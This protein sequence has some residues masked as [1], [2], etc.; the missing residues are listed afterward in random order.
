MIEE[1]GMQPVFHLRRG[2]YSGHYFSMKKPKGAR[3]TGRRESACSA[4]LHVLRRR[5]IQQEA[6]VRYAGDATKRGRAESREVGLG[7][8]LGLGHTPQFPRSSAAVPAVISF[9]LRVIGHAQVS[10]NFTIFKSTSEPSG[11]YGA[12]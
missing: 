4:S 6:R 10:L 1:G 9:I 12:S 5:N 8:G 11:V 7:L 2:V 3:Q